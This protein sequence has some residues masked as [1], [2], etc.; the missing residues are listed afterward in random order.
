MSVDSS[1]CVLKKQ[2]FQSI[3]IV[4]GTLLISSSHLRGC[5]MLPNHQEGTD[6]YYSRL[7]HT[8]PSKCNVFSQSGGGCILM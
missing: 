8:A 5:K 3:P 2:T 6:N 4:I 1:V 7:N